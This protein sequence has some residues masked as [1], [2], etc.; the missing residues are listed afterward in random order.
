M[1]RFSF[2]AIFVASIITTTSCGGPTSNSERS[3]E[4][5]TIPTWV[6][7]IYAVE[8]E[9]KGGSITQEVLEFKR[10]N[11][12]V[13]YVVCLRLDGVC[14]T[15]VLNT[16][17]GQRT[18]KDLEVGK[19]CD[20]DLSQPSYK[21][22]DYQLRDPNNIEVVEYHESVHDTLI[23]SMGRM[24]QGFD[25]TEATKVVDTVTQF[26]RVTMSGEIEKI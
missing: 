10:L 22:K 11:D 13:T 14:M 4:V 23:D 17:K 9:N 1:S 24:R 18:F 15:T 21:W 6:K 12:S 19:L 7:D 2:F 25:Y 3:D 8:I 5:D 20:H 26:Y 16:H